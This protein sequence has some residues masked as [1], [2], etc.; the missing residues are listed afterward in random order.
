MA[1]VGLNGS[2]KSTLLRQLAGTIEPETG[3]D[4]AGERRAGRDARPGRAARR[5]DGVRRDGSR[6]GV[7]GDPRPPRPRR[8]RQRARR[9][10]VGRR[11]QAGRAGE[12][13]RRGRRA[14]RGRDRCRARARRADE[15]P[16]HRRH[17]VDGGPARPAPRRA[18]PRHPRPSRARP[19]DEPDPRARPGQHVRPRGRLRGLPRGEGGAPGASRAQPRTSAATWPGPSWRGCVAVPRRE[20]ASRRRGSKRRPR[21]W[22]AVQQAAAR[23]GELDLGVRHEA[24]RRQR[25]RPRPGRPPLRRRRPDSGDAAVALPWRR[26]LARSP[27][28]TRHHRAQRGRQ[29]DAARHHRRAARSRSKERSPPASPSHSASTTSADG[30]STRR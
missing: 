12:G 28:T 5:R 1:I 27:R 11:D 24:A 14:G 9:H 10:D 29:V 25:H 17:R 19:A 16:R 23:E 22:R 26:P 20:R 8:A 21:S 18:D 4:P 15:P 30:S 2:G 6:L 7:G 13:A 3:D